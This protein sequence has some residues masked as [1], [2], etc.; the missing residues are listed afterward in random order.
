MLDW[1][2]LS[3]ELIFMVPSLFKQLEFYCVM[4]SIKMMLCYI[5]SVDLVSF[6]IVS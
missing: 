2:Y 6:N 5:Y 4:N 1:N 3:L